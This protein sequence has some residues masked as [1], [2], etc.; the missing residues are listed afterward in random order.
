MS[1]SPLFYPLNRGGDNEAGGAAE[2]QTDVMRFMAIL[3]LCLVAIFA[4]VHSIP[5]EE[6]RPREPVVEDIIEA[7]E[8][9]PAPV[10]EP[11]ETVVTA[12]PLAEPPVEST[13][14]LDVDDIELRYPVAARQK[15]ERPPEAQPAPQAVEQIEVV[16]PPEPAVVEKAQ[17]ETV[18]GFSLRF[19]DD[20]ALTRL[21]ARNE[22]GMYAMDGD[23]AMRMNVNRGSIGFWAASTPKQFHE[24]ESSTVPE[25]VLS[26]IRTREAAA[27]IKWGVTLPPGMTRQLNQY[28]NENTGGAIVIEADGGMRLER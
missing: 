3:S 19:E 9:P 4:L 25:P 10:K 21:V 13:E 23:K 20:K 18:E 1:R 28:L 6:S 15:E 2:L 7:A 11:V 8:P 12:V 27:N 24:M 16:A 26:A 17:E 5:A 22:I 14:V